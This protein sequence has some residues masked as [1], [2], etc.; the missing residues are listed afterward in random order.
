[1]KTFVVNPRENVRVQFLR[2]ILIRSLLDA[3]L[4]F[5]AAYDLATRVRSELSG[6]AEI[7][8]LTLRERV[9][10]H[11]Q[12]QCEDDF[13]EAYR[14]PLTAPTRIQV[15]TLGGQ[16]SAF[17][18]DRHERYLQSSGITSAVAE[19]ITNTIYDQL[20][21]NN[22]ESVSTCQLGYLTWLCLRQEV[23]KKAARRYLVW[24]EFQRSERPLLLLIGGALGTGKSSIASEVAH[25]LDIVRIQSTDMLR[26]VMRM[27][28]PERL[29]PIIH[30]SSYVA[31]KTL[32]IKDKQDRDPDMLVAEGFSNQA[33]LL[34]VP[35]EAILQRAERESVSVILEG[36]HVLPELLERTPDDSDA[37]AV[38]CTLAVLKSKDL[39]SRLRG[40]STH[41]PKR[42]VRNYLDHMDSIWRLQSFL[43]SEADRY[44]SPIIANDDRETTV[45]QV[46]LTVNEELSRH[47]KADPGYV[48]GN[49]VEEIGKRASNE[50]WQQ[51]VPMLING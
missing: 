29:L 33:E 45:H 21:A 12:G 25:R 10:H 4:P 14:N 2:G 17:S 9:I 22:A 24:S 37:I 49:V 30:V 7:D 23:G 18:R 50:H 15:N 48:F 20:L 8:S 1:V 46:I 34:S 35:C 31:W 6:V 42:K 5:Q 40:R 38:H 47:F 16:S 51:L 39:K 13:V 41:E 3:G 36:V 19:D 43:L 11:M 44:D 28:I 27:M 26:E 32:P